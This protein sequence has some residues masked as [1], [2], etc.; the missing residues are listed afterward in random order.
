MQAQSKRASDASHAHAR[1]SSKAA[2][3][4][5]D[6]PDKGWD[7]A[8]PASKVGAKRR[9]LAAASCLTA[10]LSVEMLGAVVIYVRAQ[11]TSAAA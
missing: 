6:L 11:A 3:W 5:A 10:C 4:L 8:H 7:R 9:L 1:V 2:Q